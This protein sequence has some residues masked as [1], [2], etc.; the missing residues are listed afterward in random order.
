MKKV[1]FLMFPIGA[2]GYGLIEI[3][4]RGYTHFSML[5]AGGI[6]FVTFAKIGEKFKQKTLL[7]RAVIGSAFVTAIELIFGIIF[8]IILK[9]DV[10]DYSKMPFNFKGQICLLYSLFWIVLGLVFIPFSLK[11]KVRLQKE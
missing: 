10:W 9:K 4:W 3:L 1:N 11:V 5:L 2:L 8:N 7:A 6:C